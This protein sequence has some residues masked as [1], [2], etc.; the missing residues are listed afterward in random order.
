MFAAAV[1]ILPAVSIHAICIKGQVEFHIHGGEI[2]QFLIY[3]FEETLKINT[4][5]N[6][7]IEIKHFQYISWQMSKL[8][9]IK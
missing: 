8:K 4:S 3:N 7:F 6:N 2:Y 9:L 1:F 5:V